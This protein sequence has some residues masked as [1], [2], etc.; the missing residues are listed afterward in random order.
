M[1]ISRKV[2]NV[3]TGPDGIRRAVFQDCFMARRSYGTGS[4]FVHRDARG[5]ETWYGKWYAGGRRVHRKIGPKR[6]RGTREGLTRAQA[7]RELQRRVELERPVL[8]S[9]LTVERAGRL[10][11]EHLEHVLERKPTTLSDYRSMLRRHVEPFFGS[12]AIERIGPDD[13]RSYLAARKRDGREP[14]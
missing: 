1:T 7:E 6:Q 13:L 4:L 11:L 14:G 12:R 5:R 10:Y 8:R 9:R 2:G 3:S